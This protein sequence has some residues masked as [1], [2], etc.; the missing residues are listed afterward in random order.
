MYFC[1]VLVTTTSCLFLPTLGVQ[2][3]FLHLRWA[4][5]HQATSGPPS[6]P[7]QTAA[8]QTLS[9]GFYLKS[10]AQAHTSSLGHPLPTY[11]TLGPGHAPKSCASLVEHACSPQP[12][13]P[14]SS[15]PSGGRGAAFLCRQEASHRASTNWLPFPR[16]LNILKIFVI[17]LAT[18][19]YNSLLA[20]SKPASCQRSPE[21]ICV[22]Q[23]HK[24]KR[25]RF[26]SHPLPLPTRKYVSSQ[27]SQEL[28]SSS[29]PHNSLLVPILVPLDLQGKMV[30]LVFG[31][32]RF[33]GCKLGTSQLQGERWKAVLYK[34]LVGPQPRGGEHTVLLCNPSSFSVNDDR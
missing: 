3:K 29:K 15:L 33:W 1:L 5:L 16:V 10:L 20:E 14:H 7:D 18:G 27:P 8:P 17:L 6:V 31:T 24:N 34:E 26:N 13:S 9:R 28:R 32:Y 21:A 2:D 4:S 30:L 22:I 11:P 25:E 19:G 23:K 12:Y